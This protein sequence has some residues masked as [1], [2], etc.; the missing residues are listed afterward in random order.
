M[1]ST[2]V[3]FENTEIAPDLLVP[4]TPTF[5]LENRDPQRKAAV[6]A[7]LAVVDE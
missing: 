6:A 1:P 7:L 5:G 2:F 3:F 4:T